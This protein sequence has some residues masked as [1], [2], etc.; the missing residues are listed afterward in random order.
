MESASG[1]ESFGIAKIA[2]FKN[3]AGVGIR[4]KGIEEAVG[5]DYE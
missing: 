3:I 4:D 1:V 2:D 5:K